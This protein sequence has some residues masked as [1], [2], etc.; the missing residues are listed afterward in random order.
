MKKANICS[1]VK[2]KWKATTNSKHVCRLL[3]TCYELNLNRFKDIMRLINMFHDHYKI[4]NYQ[5]MEHSI[6]DLQ[7]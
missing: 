1:I 4:S 5:S 3:K 7:L 6:S 2:K